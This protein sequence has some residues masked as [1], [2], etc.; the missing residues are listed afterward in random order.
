[1]SAERPFKSIAAVDDSSH[2][3]V[4]GRSSLHRYLDRRAPATRALLLGILL[5]SSWFYFRLFQLSQVEEE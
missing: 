4:P 3:E 1:M 5:L 2:V